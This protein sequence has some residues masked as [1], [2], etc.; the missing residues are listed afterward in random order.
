MALSERVGIRGQKRPSHFGSLRRELRK[1]GELYLLMTPFFLVYF[2]M[3]ILP[4]LSA[5]VL[6]L[7][8]FN[9]LQPPEW[10]GFENFRSLFV[11]DQ[12]FYIAVRNTLIFSI[13]TGPLSYILCF[14]VAWFV[15]EMPRKARVGMTLAFYAPTLSTAVYFVWQYLFSG[16]A[17]GLVNGTLMTIGILDEPVQ[18]LSDPRYNLWI[19]IL[20]QLWMSLGT[21]FLAFIAGFQSIDPSLYEAAEIDGIRNRYQELMY[22][23]LPIMKPQMLFGAVMQVAVSFSVSTLSIQ[24]CGFPSTKY[25]AHFLV[26]HM[27]DYGTIKY[28]MGYAS[29]VAVVLFLLMLMVKRAIDRLLRYVGDVDM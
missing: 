27:M 20:V 29:A 8:S 9:M 15:N 17:Y 11:D 7:T 10:I 21:S 2:L 19:L 26:L 12:V 18:W 23:T 1:H 14:M 16:D 24:L 6:S 28:E 13:L 5:S 25:S 4:V 22:V 3:T